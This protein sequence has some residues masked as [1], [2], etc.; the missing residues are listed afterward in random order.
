MDISLSP[1]LREKKVIEL[2]GELLQNHPASFRDSSGFVFEING[3]PYRW[4]N[5]AYAIDYNFLISSGLSDKLFA[6]H[7]LVRHEEVNVGQENNND[8]FKIIKPEK[9]PI[10]SY[11]YEWSFSQLKDAS[12]LTLRT[13]KTSLEYGMI[14][15]D[16]SA[17]N[18]QFRTGY[19]PIFID[20]LSFAVYEEGQPWL[21]YKQFCEHFLSPL[22]LSSYLGAEY[23]S[24]LKLSVD[25]I[26]LKMASRLL[27]W[28]SKLKPSVLMHIH[29]H[30]NSVDYYSD[31]R[32]ITSGRNRKIPK[33]NLLA[34]IDHLESFITGLEL[35]KKDKTQWQDYDKETHYADRSKISKADIVKQF[36]EIANPKVVWDIGAN[37]GFFSRLVQGENRQ[38]LSLDAD[39]LAV[40]KNYS[41]I[42]KNNCN[43]YPLVFNLT[44]PTPSIGWANKE[45]ENLT[46]RS[47]PELIMSLA[48][49]HHI[50]ITNNVPFLEVAKYF[51]NITEWLI[52]EF[53]P[54]DDE[55]VSCL[56][57]TA[58]KKN[59]C[60][61]NFDKAFLYHFES[62][63]E[64]KI[65][66]SNRS[67]LLLRKKTL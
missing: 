7:I 47:N 65:E 35:P 10:I 45:R 44:N 40:E 58:G 67:V 42:K 32:K 51:S 61:E 23:Q 14:L 55:K 52:M 57:D 43:I 21:G 18:I 41:Y 20:T 53:V 2:K 59:Y 12:L 31:K 34:M 36:V 11:P 64:L 5:R 50:V 60:R 24:L 49:I 33:R 28:Y 17:F 27:P 29:L 48:L 19:Q 66:D 6:D 15:K 25:G 30:S 1:F 54:P 62:I 46:K 37:D 38:V 22:C 16:A 56:P 3:T 63:N 26:P 39:V 4:I 8:S 9:I 13:L